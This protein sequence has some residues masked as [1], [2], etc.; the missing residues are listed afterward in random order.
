MGKA[1][2][3][4]GFRSNVRLS[5]PPGFLK[6]PRGSA[7]RFRGT[8]LMAAALPERGACRFDGIIQPRDKVYG[9]T[10]ALPASRFRLKGV[11][12]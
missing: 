10:S 6:T 4:S 1:G 9:V 3:V 12:N 8:S 5:W 2:P 7:Q 11:L